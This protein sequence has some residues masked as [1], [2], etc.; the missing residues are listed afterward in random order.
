MLEDLQESVCSPKTGS[1]FTHKLG[2]QHLKL[3]ENIST[4]PFALVE[5]LAVCCEERWPW[6]QDKEIFER[7]LS[8]KM[9]E[10]M[11]E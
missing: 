3:Q 2:I 4:L 7:F 6:Y 5:E 10:R 1:K 8:S 9:N 11:N